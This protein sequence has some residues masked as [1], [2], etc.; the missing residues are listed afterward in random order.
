MGD[1]FGMCHDERRLSGDKGNKPVDMHSRGV[2]HDARAREPQIA[3]SI[4]RSCAGDGEAAV[5]L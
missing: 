5:Y 4:P 2:S 3:E 1:R